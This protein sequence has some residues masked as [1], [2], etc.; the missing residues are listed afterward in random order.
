MLTAHVE[1]QVNHA[2][3]FKGG[4]KVDN[5]VK[6]GVIAGALD[7]LG[8]SE[9]RKRILTKRVRKTWGEFMWQQAL[10]KSREQRDAKFT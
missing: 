7:L 1:W 4:S 3:S 8:V 9:K 5:R 10:E 2:P 6:S